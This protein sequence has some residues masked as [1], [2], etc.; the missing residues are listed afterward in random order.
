[1]ESGQ[2]DRAAGGLQCGAGFGAS[3]EVS[4]WRCQQGGALRCTQLRLHLAVPPRPSTSARGGHPQ[5][6]ACVPALGGWSWP[7]RRP[8]GITGTAS[9]HHLPGRAWPCCPHSGACA[10]PASLSSPGFQPQ[11]L[12]QAAP[13]GTHAEAGGPD[14]VT[15][16]GP[17]VRA[18][19]VLLPCR[20]SVTPRRG[21]WKGSSGTAQPG[22]RAHRAAAGGWGGGPL[23]LQQGERTGPGQVHPGVPRCA[24]LSSRVKSWEAS[25][26]RDSRTIHEHLTPTHLFSPTASSQAAQRR[27]HPGLPGV[28]E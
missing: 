25:S 3:V 12:E 21:L 9:A 15:T 14:G 4:R 8:C 1:M 27:L 23:C 16:L 22:G 26:L 2:A 5:R 28:C 13:V 18:S 7:R 17:E 10:R 11:H 19:P 6:R 24:G 20:S